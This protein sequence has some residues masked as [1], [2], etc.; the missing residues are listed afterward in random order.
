MLYS[1]LAGCISE[2]LPNSQTRCN[3]SSANI[4]IIKFC[5]HEVCNYD[6]ILHTECKGEWCGFLWLPLCIS[7]GIKPFQSGAYWAQQEDT[8]Y[9]GQVGGSSTIS[10][11][12]TGGCGW[13]VQLV[14]MAHAEGKNPLR[15]PQQPAPRG[16]SLPRKEAATMASR[17]LAFVTFN[18]PIKN[19][20]SYP[21]NTPCLLRWSRRVSNG[22]DINMIKMIFFRDSCLICKSEYSHSPHL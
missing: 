5:K 20:S 21:Q 12:G 1:S 9:F 14:A 2:S 3:L 19:Y 18:A 22:T 15:L 4:W 7:A 8:V 16:V 10:Q 11:K 6:W 17:Q 13:A